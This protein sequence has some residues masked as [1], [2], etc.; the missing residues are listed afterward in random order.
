MVNT[1]IN[2]LEL[3]F[4][5][6]TMYAMA[7]I[8]PDGDM[9]FPLQGVPASRHGINILYGALAAYDE[10]MGTKQRYSVED[11]EVLIKDF[12][13]KQYLAL[14]GE[15]NK[16]ITVEADPSDISKPT[17]AEEKEAVKKK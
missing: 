4:T 17:D 7:S 9:L 6:G 5:I 1:V 8:N 11:C 10:K 16:L 14:L 2:G 12:S 15:Y 3:R 13:G